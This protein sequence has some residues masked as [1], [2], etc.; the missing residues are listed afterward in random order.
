MADCLC[1]AS[2]EQR[3]DAFNHEMQSLEQDLAL[4]KQ[5]R[6][7]NAVTDPRSGQ[8]HRAK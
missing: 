5:Y 2:C 4:L 7:D 1:R 6:E 3:W 8:I